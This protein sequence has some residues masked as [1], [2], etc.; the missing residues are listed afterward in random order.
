MSALLAVTVILPFAFAVLAPGLGGS[1]R[2]RPAFCVAYSLAFTGLNL[3]LLN[4]FLAEGGL[5]WGSL[6]VDRLNFPVFLVLNLLA[7]AVILYAGFESSGADGFARGFLIASMFA[8]SG[9]ASLLVLARGLL[10]FAV[11]W[12][13]VT[14]AALA[15]LL[16]A[17]RGMM[18]RRLVAFLPWLVSDVLFLSGAVL[19]KVLLAE[20]AV[21][22]EPP[23][24]AGSEAGV[25]V[26]MLLFLASVLLRLSVFPFSFWVADLAD[27]ADPA[28]SAMFLG[29]VNFLV[30]G[31]RLLVVA[32]LIA[33]LAAADWSVLLALLGAFSVVAGPVYALR[34]RRLGQYV[35]GMY[36]FEA[37][38]LL[39]GV[40]L[41]SRAGIESATYSLLVAPLAITAM[42]FACGTVSYLKGGSEL[43]QNRLS[44]RAARA[45]FAALLLS[46]V[47]IA[48]LPPMGGFVA[49]ALTALAGI[50]RAF[51]APLYALLAAAGLAGAA[52]V[53]AALARVMSRLF[54]AK[55]E[56]L[57]G[58]RPAV[59]AGLA[60]LAAC[61]ASLL[62]GLFPGILLRNFIAGGSRLLF[63]TGF[64]GPGVVFRGSGTAIA[65]AFSFYT[66]WSETA[67][68]FLFVVLVLAVA[69]FFMVDA[70]RHA[71]PDAGTMP[72]ITCE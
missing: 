26:V 29:A 42:L 69:A 8:G 12:E 35:S 7:A 68:A 49:R 37:G 52:V 14:L 15:G 55:G 24:T 40:A 56:P 41:Y 53:V 6:R 60:A 22:I 9:F 5:A 1:A 61:G 25:T 10:A 54:A 45:A 57:T 33:R 32:A 19:S 30:A 17:G 64:E 67:A 36:A 38:F 59:A 23:L 16:V 31:F 39:A 27:R 71:R 63:R 50:E 11:L 20:S 2:L 44:P 66:T 51:V 72:D 21:L 47:S 62:L 43:G 34:S 13:A 58:R 48:G 46:G 4:G 65:H 70:K 18:R 3:V 28:W